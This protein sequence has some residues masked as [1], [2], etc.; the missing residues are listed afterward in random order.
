MKKSIAL[1]VSAC[2]LLGG[3]QT[4]SADVVNATSNITLQGNI[5]P[6]C[7]MNIPKY[8]SGPGQF[9]ATGTNY[10]AIITFDAS[11]FVDSSGKSAVV[12]ESFKFPSSMC[13]FSAF[14]ALRSTNKGM[15]SSTV[16]SPGFTN[17]VNYTATA[18]IGTFTATLDTSG[19]ASK[20]NTA[21]T[22]FFGDV[23]VTV[24]TQASALP[25]VG[26]TTPYSDVLVVQLGQAL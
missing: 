26:D 6:T 20:V 10:D 24:A 9:S 11:Q 22:P 14:L 3:V 7:M 4:A 25:L 5:N 15:T 12:T 1:S 16:A 8:V 2:V 13:N 17:T 19:T 23:T 21:I 18:T